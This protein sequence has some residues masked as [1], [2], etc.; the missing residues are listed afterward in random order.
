[1]IDS[2]PLFVLG[3]V[4]LCP[5]SHGALAVGV[6]LGLRGLVSDGPVLSG[7]LVFSLAA[8][9]GKGYVALK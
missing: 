9:V 7:L 1:L 2:S 5:F 8:L 4:R 6:A 3:V